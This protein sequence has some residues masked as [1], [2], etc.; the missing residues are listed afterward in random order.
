MSSPPLRDIDEVAAGL[1]VFVN[2]TIMARGRPIR[3]DDAFE[4][5][6][7]A[8]PRALATDVHLPSEGPV[9][10]RAQRPRRLPLRGADLVLTAMHSR[11]TRAGASSN[12]ILAVRCDARLDPERLRRALDRFLDV[13]PWP[14][15]RLRRPFP[16]GALHW[17]AGRRA[18]LAAAG[19]AGR[20]AGTRARAR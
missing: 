10:A 20:G 18:A 1:T 15:A 5:A 17:A 7:V 6:G 14:A 13:C 2:A 3:P 11:W 12:A 4:T 16:W 19:A 8:S 9:L